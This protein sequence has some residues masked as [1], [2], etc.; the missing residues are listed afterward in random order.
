MIMEILEVF[1]SIMR[2]RS[3][4]V[5]V[6][7][8]VGRCFSSG[9]DLQS[10]GPEGDEFPPLDPQF[11]LPHHKLISLIREIHIPVIALLHGYSLGA[12]YEL[13]LACDFRLAA[14]DLEIGDHRTTRA[15]CM[16]HGA[17]W[18]LPRLIGFARA[19]EI[20]L[21]GR[22]LDAK[23]ALEIGLVNRVY[24]VDQF[25]EKSKEFIQKIAE[26]PTRCLGYNKAMFNYSF[27]NDLTSSLQNE[28]YLFTENMKTSDYREGM[29]SFLGKREPQFKGK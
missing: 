9:D 22:H 15:I 25:N 13:A 10:M 27:K 2:E 29:R 7:N 20:V 21:T 8:G 18:F 24:P 3:I 5:I 11:K 28:F 17:S 1:E 6:F 16:L 12:G 4:R 14:D 19:T 23:E 26:M